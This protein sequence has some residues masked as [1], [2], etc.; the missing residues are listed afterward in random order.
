MVN[1]KEVKN[2]IIEKPEDIKKKKKKKH[3][4]HSKH[5]KHSSDKKEKEK[6]AKFC[7]ELYTEFNICKFGKRQC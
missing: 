7:Q 4:H 2:D 5:K 1:E 6:Y 3:K